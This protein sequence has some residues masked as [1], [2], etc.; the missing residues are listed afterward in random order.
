MH[1][2]DNTHTLF[3]VVGGLHY[4]LNFLRAVSRAFVHNLDGDDATIVQ[5]LNHFL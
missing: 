1:P 5:P 4:S 2:G 3:V